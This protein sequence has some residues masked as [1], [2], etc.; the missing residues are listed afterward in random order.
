MNATRN[1]PCLSRFLPDSRFSPLSESYFTR[2]TIPLQVARKSAKCSRR[3]RLS[4]RLR[5]RVHAFLTPRAS[6]APREAARVRLTA[7]TLTPSWI[8]SP[9]PPLG[10]R[11][12]FFS[13][14]LISRRWTRGRGCDIADDSADLYRI[15]STT[16]GRLGRCDKSSILDQ[17]QRF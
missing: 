11:A 17:C 1:L 8:I 12:I 13:S 3:A 2:R 14:L 16:Y 10:V 7:C 15:Y 4:R 5:M 9:P 6:W